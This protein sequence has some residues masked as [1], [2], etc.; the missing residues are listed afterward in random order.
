M[1]NT[2]QEK[3]WDRES[4]NEL[5]LRSRLAME[6]ALMVVYQ[7]QTY[8]E[9][10]MEAT[11]VK[12]GVG[13]TAYDAEFMSSLAKWVESGRHLSAGQLR[14]LRK[15]NKSGICRMARYHRQLIEA[16]ERKQRS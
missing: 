12:N 4:I 5:L 3:K 9:Q 6:R 1:T 15:K 8:D 14:V 11:V 2:T 7:N 13:F 10:A 16:I